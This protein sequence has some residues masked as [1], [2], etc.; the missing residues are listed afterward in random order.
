[1][2]SNIAWRSSVVPDLQSSLG[3]EAALLGQLQSQ[4]R[5]THVR[6]APKLPVLKI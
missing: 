5:V 6:F 4:A 1:M 2:L 3:L